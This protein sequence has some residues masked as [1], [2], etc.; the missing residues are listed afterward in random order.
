[1]EVSVCLVIVSLFIA[2]IAGSA[3]NIS[4]P[5]SSAA[6]YVVRS[7]PGVVTKSILTVG[8]SV[9]LKPDGITPYRLVGIPDGLGAFDNGDGTFTL[10]MNHEL[11]ATAGI[12]REHGAPGAFVSKWIIRKGSLEVLHGEDLIHNIA[13]WNTSLSSYNA[14]AT[15]IALGRLCSA[16]LA[17]KS[18]FFNEATGLGF[19]GRLFLSGEEVGNE[20]RLFGHTLSGTSYELSRLGKFSWENSVANPATGNKTVVVGMDDST[21]G[22][23]YVYIG[24]KSDTGNPVQ[25]AGLS[26]GNLYGVKVNGIATESR[27]NGIASGTQFTL[28]NL[29]N[30]QNKTGATIQ[31]DSVAG[32]V[33]EFLRPEDGAW[34]PSNP[35]DFY[36]VTTDRFDTV[37]TNTGSQVGRSRLYRLRFNNLAD[38]TAGGHID[39]VLD[40]T[41]P[42][43]MMDNITITKRGEVV[44]QEDPGNQVHIAKVWR[45]NIEN[46]TLSLVGHHDENKFL[47]G[48]LE[49]LTQDEES[50]G[51]IDASDILG[52]GW[53][54]LDVQ[55]H[56][57][58]AGELV[59]G[60]Q[61]LALHYPPGRK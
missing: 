51:I 17:A 54:L 36:F 30:V 29:G 40:G 1:M 58:L 28:H 20:G 32:G 52:E 42:Q 7:V 4:G 59:E 8:D 57:S 35:K 5:S 16:D 33:T 10:L 26:N 44:I 41:E 37:K 6:P 47:A 60:G 39:M 43:Q 55:A 38:L 3:K 48:G 11:P 53:F 24:D 61:L 18:A 49:F 14:P 23:V 45:Y 27:D 9:N 15:G 56:Y 31:T 19:D 12:V 50:S 21:P 34:D 46:D 25:K 2:T 13:T 22:Q